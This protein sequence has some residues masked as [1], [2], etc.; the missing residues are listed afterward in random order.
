MLLMRAT[1]L[2]LDEPRWSR[3]N[4]VLVI[5]HSVYNH[6]GVVKDDLGNTNPVAL[7]SMI[8]GPRLSL[9]RKGL[10]LGLGLLIA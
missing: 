5:C 1:K 4:S 2:I 6:D 10:V 3:R 8:A 9:L 7:A